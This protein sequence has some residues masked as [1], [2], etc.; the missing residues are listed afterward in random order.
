MRK[1]GILSLVLGFL[2]LLFL[3]QAVSAQADAV[4][5][6]IPFAFTVET[7]MLPAGTYQITKVKDGNYRMANLKGDQKAMFMTETTTIPTAVASFTLMF[8]AY[9]DQCY[10]SK[11]FH[12]GK[13]VGDALRQTAAEKELALKVK[14]TTKIVEKGK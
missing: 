4:T 3:P 14:P 10:L 12:Q 5:I 11:F 9:G 8:N 2:A 1:I 6:D 7:T 13:T